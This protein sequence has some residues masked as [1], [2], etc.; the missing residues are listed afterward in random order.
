MGGDVTLGGVLY[1]EQ[2]RTF[3]GKEVRTSL[4]HHFFYE[5][6]SYTDLLIVS[7]AKTIARAAYINGYLL[8]TL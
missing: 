8:H 4:I 2:T 1:V 5:I 6:A 3:Q 7:V